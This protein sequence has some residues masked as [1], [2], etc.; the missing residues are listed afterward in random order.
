MSVY[1][2]Q[3]FM[4][5]PGAPRQP[6]ESEHPVTRFASL[7]PAQRYQGWWQNDQGRKDTLIIESYEECPVIDGQVHIPAYIH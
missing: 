4:V 7:G 5:V 6:W 1:I 3:T 2:L